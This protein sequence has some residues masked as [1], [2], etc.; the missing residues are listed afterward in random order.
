MECDAKSIIAVLGRWSQRS[1][2][3]IA[4]IIKRLPHMHTMDLSG[5]CLGEA[6]LVAIGNAS[7]CNFCRLDRIA[8]RRT[9]VQIY[10]QKHVFPTQ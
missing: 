3:T 7:S 4:E 6:G 1:C 5:N 10:A 8:G 9:G 2:F